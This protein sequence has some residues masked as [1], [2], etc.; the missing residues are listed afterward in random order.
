MGKP[1]SV[2]RLPDTSRQLS[3]ASSVRITSQ[4]FCMKTVLG[5][6]LCSAMR[7]TQW[8]TGASGSGMYSDFKPLLIGFQFLPPSSVRNAP[9]A[10]MAMYMRL[11]FFGSMQIV[12]SPS[13]P[14]PGDHLSPCAERRAA[15][16]CQV[17]PPS[18]VLNIAAS[19]TPAKTVFASDSDG[20][21]CQTRLNTH[22]F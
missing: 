6:D 1:K 5:L 14:A 16:S 19:S 3:P 21:R 15:N 20:S 4:C 17:L 12:W 9:A 13:P 8:P 7:C 10:E 2:G 18:V 22:G 11:G